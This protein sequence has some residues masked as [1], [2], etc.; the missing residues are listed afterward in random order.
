MVVRDASLGVV[1]ISK[2][3]LGKVSVAIWDRIP[4]CTGEECAHKAYC[5]Y[6]EGKLEKVW[7]GGHLGAC[8]IRRKF[9]TVNTRPF[10]DLIETVQDE[11]VS[12]WVGMHLI[13][14]YMDLVEFQ[15][16]KWTVKQVSYT[17]DRGMIRVHP[18]YEEIRRTHSEILKAWKTT[19][20]LQIARDAGYFQSKG[21]KII[22]SEPD[23]LETTR[24]GAAGGY[25]AINK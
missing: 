13:P 6:L 18:I 25:S 20:L 10:L 23:I 4:D 17:D 19:G 5:P 3:V 22:P 16:E 8:S 1:Q 9:L 7:N 2:G 11:F 14:L 24:E 15:M 12:Q 21:G